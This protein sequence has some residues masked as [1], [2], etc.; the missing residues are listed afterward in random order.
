VKRRLAGVEIEGDPV[1]FN[2]TRWPVSRDGAS[3]GHVT[4][5][6]YSPRLEKNIGYA[7][8]PVELAELGTEL[9]V[10]V[11]QSGDR[12]ARVARKPFVDPKKE[13]PKS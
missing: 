10:A 11:P 7:M 12:P 9:T 5:A 3:V 6:I 1:E 8:L 4:S 2:M 13:I